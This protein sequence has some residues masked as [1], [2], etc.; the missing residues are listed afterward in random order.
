[1]SSATPPTVRRRL[2]RPLA[3]LLYGAGAILVVAA[4]WAR[5]P[6][7]LFAA[8]PLLLAPVSGL[9]MAPGE[10]LRARLT[11]AAD[12][13]GAEVVLRGTI[14]VEGAIDARRV[15]VRFYTIEPLVEVAPPELE[16]RDTEIRFVARYRAPY[17]CLL[18]VPRPDVLWV[19]PLALLEIPVSLSGDALRV[20]RFP[21][22]VTNV[23]RS[24]LERTTSA[25]GEIRSRAIGSA[26]EFFAV[27]TAAP[28]DTYRQ[29]NWWATARSGRLLANDYHLERTGDLVILLDLRP[30][31]L[32]P[33][34]DRQLLAV[35]RAAALGIASGF[36][37]QKARVGLGLYE[38]FLTA[39]PLGSG[40]VQQY[41]LQVALQ[42]AE[43]AVTPGPAERLG[44]S[45]R[46][47]FPPGVTT[48]LIS[49]LADEEGLLVLPHLRRRGFPA[50]VL[51]PSPLPLFPPSPTDDHG[52]AA[53]ATRLL[54]LVRRARVGEGWREASVIEWE[55]YWSL[56]PLVDFL[57][58]PVLRRN[59]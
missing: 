16:V 49:S 52:E 4:F 36:L 27:R 5:S 31:S 39:V 21:P 26:G 20:E 17:P 46:R 32:G 25:P 37:A 3:F 13:A 22:E 18:I 29:I 50:F 38:E 8:L 28:S 59:R 55:D 48:L 14:E 6:V 51:S 57:A 34:K 7:P 1:V 9:V 40:R 45:M 56:A 2:W 42:R 23:G 44:V 35:S 53:L 43:I 58:R 24:R 11:W 19:D 33:E 15:E 30:T 12:G 47:Y 10:A 41:R 54:R